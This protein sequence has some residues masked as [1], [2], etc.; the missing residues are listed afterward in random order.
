MSQEQEAEVKQALKKQRA[1]LEQL[2]SLKQ[3]LEQEEEQG[4]MRLLRK[5]VGGL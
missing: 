2:V 5:Q 1:Q 3:Q 4:K